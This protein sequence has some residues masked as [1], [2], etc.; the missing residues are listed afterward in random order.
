MARVRDTA[1]GRERTIHFGQHGAAQFRDS[2]LRLYA[3]L[4]HRDPGRRRSYFRRH[5]G[6]ASKTE[7]LRKERRL[8]GGRLTAKILSHTYLW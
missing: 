8:A 2:A 3:D 7:A 1:T 6:K 4:D 5:S